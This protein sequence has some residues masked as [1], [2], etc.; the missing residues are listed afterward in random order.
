M[1][2]RSTLKLTRNNTN[3]SIMKMRKKVGNLPGLLTMNLT[4]PLTRSIVLKDLLKKHQNTLLL[5]KSIKKVMRFRISWT[6]SNFK[7]SLPSRKTTNMSSYR[8]SKRT[9]SSCQLKKEIL[10]SLFVLNP[11]QRSISRI[12]QHSSPPNNHRRQINTIG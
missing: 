2:S 7:C 4:L 3:L 11:N 9:E 8:L 6:Q 5:S 12:S 1:K 10:L